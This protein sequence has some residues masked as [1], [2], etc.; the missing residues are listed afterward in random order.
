MIKLGLIVSQPIIFDLL[1]EFIEKR[2]F[3]TYT[4]V[5]D[6]IFPSS[7]YYSDWLLESNHQ[8]YL[9]VGYY[10]DQNRLCISAYE[11]GFCVKR[12]DIDLYDTECFDKFKRWLND[13]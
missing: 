2:G 12:L 3:R 4:P 9:A 1:K 7:Y 5:N 6:S 8:I 10:I 11:Y 13:I